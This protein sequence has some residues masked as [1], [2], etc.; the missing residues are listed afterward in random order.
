SDTTNT[1]KLNKIRNR[2]ALA[3]TAVETIGKNDKAKDLKEGEHVGNKDVD[4][5]IDYSSVIDG[6]DVFIEVKGVTRDK[7]ERDSGRKRRDK[8]RK[9]V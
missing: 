9:W 2:R 3:T 7:R 8:V 4:E 6:G 5:L 1:R